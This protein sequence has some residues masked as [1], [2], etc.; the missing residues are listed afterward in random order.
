MT[1]SK[2]S[3]KN[4][5]ISVIH[6][7][8]YIRFLKLGRW[9]FVERTNCTSIVIILAMT[10][11]RKVI[12]TEQYR[13]PVKKK[14]IEFPAGLVNDESRNESIFTA[15]KRELLE[16][17]GYRAGRM[18]RLLDGPVSSGFTSDMVTVLQAKD[19]KKAGP[20]GGD[21]LENIAVYEV[22]LAKA[23]SWLA[24]MQKKGRLVD[25]KVYAGLYFLN[26]NGRTKIS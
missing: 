12:F 5:K 23:E 22:P 8:K 14:V 18:V 6:E 21:K 20:G 25:P 26:K 10:D 7:G 9:E 2:N 3:F 15:A 24:Q 4:K 13:P 19:I 1:L 16:E 17:T 11:D